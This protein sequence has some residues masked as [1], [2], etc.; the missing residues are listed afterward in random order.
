MS[1]LEG[2]LDSQYFCRIH[3][4]YI[5]NINYLVKIEP[6]S[7]DSRIAKLKNGKSLPISRSGY[8]RLLELIEP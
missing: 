2:K 5:L 3:R 4:S 6:Y 7:K 8:S 1:N